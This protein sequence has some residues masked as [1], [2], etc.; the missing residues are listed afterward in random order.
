M[1]DHHHRTAP[2]R[3]RQRLSAKPWT[4]LPVLIAIWPSTS[5][6]RRLD[7]PFRG[8]PKTCPCPRAG[9][10]SAISA[11]ETR[12][13]WCAT[14]NEPV[15]RPGRSER[16]FVLVFDEIQKIPNWSEAVKGMWD[17]D[18][19]QGRPL[20]VVLLGSA[21]LLM[22]EGMSE[23]LAGRFE[24]IRLTHWSFEEMAAAFDF[25]LSRYVYF[26]GYPGAAPLIRQQD[27]WRKYILNSL[28]EPNIE[29]DVIAMQRIHKPAL[30]KRLFDLGAEYSGQ[31]L[32]YTKMMGQL[33]DAGNTTTLSRYLNLLS[34]AGLVTGLPK[35]AGGAYRRR[36]SSPKLN[37]LNTA[38]MSAQ[39]DYTFQEASADRSFWGTI[40]GKRRRRPSVQH[41]L[42]P[43]SPLLLA[44][45]RPRGGFRPETRPTV[46]CN[47]GEKRFAAAERQRTSPVRRTLQSR[48]ID[49]GRWKWHPAVR[50]SLGSGVGVV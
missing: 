6:N 47:R 14:G 36:A 25:D 1:A 48:K 35:Y 8:S 23:S 3:A 9:L 40:G 29:R 32:S 39:S 30:L 22:Q 31:I 42:P 5:L 50:V 26:G 24:T 10:S 37:V 12:G 44:T 46:G 17:A 13:G 4:G 49:S 28:V 2:G 45:Q 19:R 11:R 18:R 27:R 7:L 33:Q 15:S 21:P 38:L 41:G 16:G 20:H 34:A 43:A